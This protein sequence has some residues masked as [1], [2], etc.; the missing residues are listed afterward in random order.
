MSSDDSLGTQVK[1]TFMKLAHGAPSATNPITGASTK[2]DGVDASLA[3]PVSSIAHPPADVNREDLRNH[4]AGKNGPDA[5]FRQIGKEYEEVRKAG[6]IKTIH[7]PAHGV[8]SN[9]KSSS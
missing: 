4:G 1:E 7:A 5:D 3:S 6:D 8:P 9:P 2:A